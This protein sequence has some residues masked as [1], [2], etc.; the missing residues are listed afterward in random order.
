MRKIQLITFFLALV[1][2]NVTAQS[3]PFR[4]GV[5]LYPNYSNTWTSQQYNQTAGKPDGRMGYT[6]GL[7]SEKQLDRHWRSRVG[8]NYAVAGFQ[9]QEHAYTWPSEFSTGTYVPDPAL[10]KKGYLIHEYQ[11]IEIPLDIHFIVKPGK[12]FFLSAGIAPAIQIRKNVISVLSY[13]DGHKARKKSAQS[14]NGTNI[15]LHLGAGF[16]IPLYKKL[17]LDIQPDFQVSRVISTAFLGLRASQVGIK[18]GLKI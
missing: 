10:A 18:F 2:G 9:D 13:Q 5:S 14:S 12:T 3:V 1:A 15:A 4:F 7:F 11:S 17:I 16:S 8:I 6:F